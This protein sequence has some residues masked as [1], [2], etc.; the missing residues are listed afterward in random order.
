MAALPP[1]DRLEPRPALICNV[2][3]FVLELERLRRRAASGSPVRRVGLDQLAKASGIP[4]SS[5]HSYLNG[6]ALPP[7]ERLDALVRALGCRP[8][9]L[10]EWAQALDRLGDAAAA[11]RIKPVGDDIA[12]MPTNN[13]RV[14][15]QRARGLAACL[16][17]MYGEASADGPV[18]LPGFVCATWVGTYVYAEPD[19]LSRRTG[20]LWA[21]NNWFICQTRGAE[22][23]ALGESVATDI[24]LYTQGDVAHDGAG[25]WGWIPAGAVANA[26]PHTPFPTLPWRE[27]DA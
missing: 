15:S 2:S 18:V 11:D 22:N 12:R 7:A 8:E 23:P 14:R 21:G 13:A 24:W 3:D 20:Y 26:R 25:A 1:D 27:P 6:S 16:Q 10:K 4:R 19:P 5:V 17:W 9:E